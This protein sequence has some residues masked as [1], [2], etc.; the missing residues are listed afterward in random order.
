VHVSNKITL[1]I[2]RPFKLAADGFT[3]IDDT[4]VHKA[5]REA[6]A[7]C[8]VN[9]HYYGERGLVIKKWHDKIE[10]ANPGTF[11]IGL[12]EALSGGI[13][14]P[15]NSVL[16]KIFNLINIGER[17]GSGI[18]S[19]MSVWKKQGWRQPH[20]SEDF[21]AGRTT[22]SLLFYTTSDRSS[23]KL[24]IKNSDAQTTAVLELAAKYSRITAA[25]VA[26]LLSIGMGRSRQ[27]LSSMVK[28]NL[29][30]TYGKNKFRTY[31]LN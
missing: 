2:K 17:A 24:A 28:K 20:Y 7:N 8:L 14:Q 18:P 16:L 6:L 9:A 25:Q 15:R 4:P 23:D 13:S 1:D 11:R 31:G 5:L 29:L 22:L 10:F 19:I 27:I 3:R 21:Q 12:E 26:D 30:I